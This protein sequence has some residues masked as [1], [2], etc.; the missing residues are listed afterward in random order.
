METPTEPPPNSNQ[1]KAL[2]ASAELAEAQTKNPPLGWGF[3]IT[4][5]TLLAVI[6]FAQAL[7]SNGARV[8]SLLSVITI[9][10]VGSPFVFARSGY[11][12]V[13]PDGYATFPYF[14]TLALVVGVPAIF[15]LSFDISALWFVAGT[16]AAA[17]TLEM[18]RKYQKWVSRRA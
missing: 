13:W 18:G 15:A 16:L 6:C 11:G 8:V 3:F 9:V 2:L 12:F 5:A 10:A 4:Q 1:A 17:V 14:L 7:P